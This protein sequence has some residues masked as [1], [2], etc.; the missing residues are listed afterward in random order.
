ML[1]QGPANLLSALQAVID[2]RKAVQRR[3]PS[4]K[5]IALQRLLPQ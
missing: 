3:T 5:T 2:Q 4:R 1:R